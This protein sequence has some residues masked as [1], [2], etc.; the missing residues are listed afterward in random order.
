MVFSVLLTK[1]AFS[2]SLV[3]SDLIFVFYV[4]LGFLWVYLPSHVLNINKLFLSRI[5]LI[6][7]ARRASE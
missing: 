4:Y 1:Q 5:S 3:C 7:R 6:R 2:V